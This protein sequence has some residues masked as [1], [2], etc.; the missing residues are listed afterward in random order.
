[1]HQTSLEKM[2]KFIFDYLCFNQEFTI[3]DVGS[4]SVNGSYKEIFNKKNWK[5][6][7][8]DIVKGENVDVVLKNPFDWSKELKDDLFDIVVSGQTFEHVERPWEVMTEISR[9]MKPGAICCIIAPSN[10]EYHEPPDCWRFYSDGMKAL[11]NY[12][13]LEVI[14][15]VT[16]N[17][18]E[19]RDTILIA[20]KPDA[21]DQ[22][23]S[24]KRIPKT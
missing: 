5:Y 23:K 8:A 4:L 18:G 21:E 20:R 1:M 11:A 14:S 6:V 3:L 17:A 12:A 19:W 7:G 13:N 16:D 15:C 22:N 10:G 2:K 9:V 24:R